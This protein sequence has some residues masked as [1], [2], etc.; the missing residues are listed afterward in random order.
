MNTPAAIRINGV[1][2][3][4][5]ERTRVIFNVARLPTHTVIDLP[6]YVYRA[7]REG[8]TLLLTAGL[9]GDE[10]NG[11]ETLRRLIY[12][13]TIFPEIGT[14]VA[15]PVVNIFGFIHQ[16]RD[17]PD[18]K[19]LNRSFPGSL[20]GSLARRLAHIVMQEILPHA[21][22]GV[23]FHT[24]GA[25]K[26]N[27]PHIRCEFNRP[28]NLEL[29][30]ALAPPFIVNSTP[31]AG[32]LRYAAARVDIPVLTFEGGESLRLHEH[33]VTAGI[34]GIRRLMQS[35]GMQTG[36]TAAE[37]S[38]E[39]RKSWWNR[40]PYSGLFSATV[41][42]GERVAKNQV[43]GY[44]T[45]PFGEIRYPVKARSH[46]YIIGINNLCVISKG[47]ALIHVGTTG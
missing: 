44:I 33:T 43:L 6:V 11:I 4:P 41:S 31:P 34:S 23:D 13:R 47:V 3:G 22:L 42:L 17:L 27:H 14:V 1:S 35:L 2:I 36:E 20:R 8:P 32:S 46:G 7:R 21:E 18:G 12:T 45:D 25:S 5:G 29:A 38:I 15:V 30:R 19:D 40:A 26:C 10:I 24:G 39:L 16:S 28:R 9:H 37:T